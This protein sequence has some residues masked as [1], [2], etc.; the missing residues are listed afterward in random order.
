MAEYSNNA[1]LAA[2]GAPTQEPNG[3]QEPLAIPSNTV[4]L[5]NIVTNGA[6]LNQNFSML[7]QKINDLKAAWGA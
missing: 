1:V 3:E 4:A 7:I 5:R 2:I 6:L